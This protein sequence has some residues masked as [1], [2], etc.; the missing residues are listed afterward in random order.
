MGEIEDV[1]GIEAE[2]AFVLSVICVID[3][4]CTIGDHNRCCGVIPASCSPCI[5]AMHL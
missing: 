2:H 4:T 1:A 3:I 5:P